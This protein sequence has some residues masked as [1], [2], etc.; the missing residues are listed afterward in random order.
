MR[1]SGK[2]ESGSSFHRST[3]HDPGT[4]I[5]TLTAISS[6]SYKVRF[7]VARLKCYT[8]YRHGR[9]PELLIRPIQVPGLVTSS[10][11]FHPASE[12]TDEHGGNFDGGW[13]F[14]RGTPA[15]A[16]PFL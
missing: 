6:G 16:A 1:I 11:L 12:G 15:A 3:K 7:V 10:H 5:G 9:K 13:K 4:Y 8:F 14:F 2:L